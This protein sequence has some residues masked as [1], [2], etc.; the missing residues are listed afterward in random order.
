MQTPQLDRDRIER[1]LA[2]GTTQMPAGLTREEKRRVLSGTCTV[3]PFSSRMC[4]QGTRGCPVDH[5][6]PP[7][8]R[9]P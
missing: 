2:S 1:A 6:C 4:Q 3:E 5:D 7:F 9:S 8:K